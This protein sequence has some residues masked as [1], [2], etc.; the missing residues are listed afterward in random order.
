MIPAS[1]SGLLPFVSLFLLRF[2]SA[3]TSS[4]E[5]PIGALLV[6][7]GVSRRR[8]YEWEDGKQTEPE[9]FG[10]PQEKGSNRGNY[11][12]RAKPRKAI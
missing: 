12:E 9:A 4:L 11:R 2:H 6:A 10:F 8:S 3:L 7:S 5:T 1:F